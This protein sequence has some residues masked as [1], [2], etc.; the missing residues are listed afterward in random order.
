MSYEGDDWFVCV[1]GHAEIY[2]CYDSPEFEDF[3]CP[4]CGE[5]AAA[6]GSVDHTNGSDESDWHAFDAAQ[7]KY[8]WKWREDHPEDFDIVRWHRGDIITHR[9]YGGVG[10][11]V[12]EIE[13]DED[14]VGEPLMYFVAWTTKP[15]EVVSC[16]LGG[17][18]DKFMLVPDEDIP[19]QY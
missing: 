14:H 9:E 10:V 2:G 19:T 3:K 12:R 5:V 4:K 6:C 17:Q 1:K 16:W 8:F 13:G 7:K 15:R 18:E 11:V